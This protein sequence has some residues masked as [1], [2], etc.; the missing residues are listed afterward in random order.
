MNHMRSNL[1]AMVAV[2]FLSACG[3]SPTGNG[4]GDDRVIIANPLFATGIQE[5]FTRTG[6]TASNCHGSSTQGGL[7]LASA[8]ASF[9][10]LVNVTSVGNPNGVRVV[11]NDAVNSYLVQRLEG[12]GGIRMPQGLGAL[13]NIDM[14]NIM[15]WINTGALNN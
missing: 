14:T 3:D 11:P 2:V 6:C 8:S 15:N 7:G 12:T 1:F 5:I 13:D 4:G 9:L 10:D